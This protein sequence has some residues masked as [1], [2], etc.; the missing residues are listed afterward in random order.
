MQESRGAHAGDAGGHRGHMG[1]AGDMEGEEFTQGR[2]G[3]RRALEETR[4]HRKTQVL[5]EPRGDM[6]KTQEAGHENDRE[7]RREHEQGA[8]R[9]TQAM[10]DPGETAGQK[11]VW[12]QSM[13]R[14]PERGHRRGRCNSP[15][16][17][18]QPAPGMLWGPQTPPR[19]GENPQLTAQSSSWPPSAQWSRMCGQQ[20]E[21]CSRSS[22]RPAGHV[23]W[24]QGRER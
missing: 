12:G 23:E 11:R 5:R 15:E 10:G 14:A 24:E 18:A 21:R 2:G 6:G 3:L 19:R 4:G 7:D 20:G 17:G 8:K 16:S 13:A 22:G 1:H 9:A